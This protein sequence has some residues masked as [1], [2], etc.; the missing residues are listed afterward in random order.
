MRILFL[1]LSVVSITAYPVT[2]GAGHARSMELVTVTSASTRLGPNYGENNGSF[3]AQLT[4]AQG[5][6]LAGVS[7]F[8]VYNGSSLGSIGVSFPLGNNNC[9]TSNL[10]FREFTVPASTGYEPGKAVAINKEVCVRSKTG[11]S[12]TSGTIS[13]TVW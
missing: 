13:I 4:L 10:N 7:Q 3:G 6:S 8:A 1:L 9:K 12:L 5:G 11:S 2:G